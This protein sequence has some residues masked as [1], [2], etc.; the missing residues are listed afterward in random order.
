MPSSGWCGPSH[1]VGRDD[2]PR[3][4]SEQIDG[5][6]GMVPEQMVGPR[7]RLALGVDV[8]GGGRN[9][10]ARP[11]AGRRASPAA[12]LLWIYW[13]LGLNRRVWPTIATQAGLL[14]LGQ[15]RLRIGE[16][17]GRAG[18]RPGHACRRPGTGCAWAACIWV[19]V[20]EDHRVEARLRQRLG[21]LGRGMADAIFVGD[22]PASARACARRRETTSTPSISFSAVEMLLPE[23]AG[24]GQA[25]F[26]PRGS[27]TICPTAVLRRRHVIMAV[28]LLHLVAERAAHDQPHDQLD[29]L[30]DPP[31]A[32]IRYAACGA[33]PADRRSARRGIACPMRVL[34]SPARGPWSWWLIPP[35]PQI[36]TLRSSGKLVDRARDRLA[37]QP[38]AIARRRRIGDDVDRQRDDPAPAI[39]RPGRRSATAARSARDRPS[40]SLMMVMSNSSRMQLWAMCQARSGWPFTTGTGRGP[41]PSSAVANSSAQPIAKVGMIRMSKAEAWSL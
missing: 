22:L 41:Q 8:A 35:V 4:I 12:I 14:L 6:R 7:A 1:R 33:A 10:S 19:G 2:R 32:D 26:M 11:S 40:I 16:A 29:P 20:H 28:Q 13:W 37:E 36:W 21:Q 34:I 27:S 23:R 18:S 9:R 25:I 5:V 30:A 15:H 38:A 24:A 39:R 3:L 17:V 31:R